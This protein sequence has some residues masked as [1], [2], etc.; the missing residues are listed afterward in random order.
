[1]S[2]ET[3]RFA[4]WSL[5]SL[6]A[7]AVLTLIV[8][9]QTNNI[10][11]APLPDPSTTL[12]STS[13]TG[14]A[15]NLGSIEGVI[16]PDGS[17]VAFRT[18]AFNIT[19]PESIQNSTTTTQVVVKDLSTGAV[20]VVSVD[21]DGNYGNGVFNIN[22]TTDGHHIALSEDGRFVA[23]TYTGSNLIPNDVNSNDVFV[24]D[25]QT[26]ITE[27]ISQSTDGVQANGRSEEPAISADGRYVAFKS[28]A[29]NLDPDG[30]PGDGGL[31]GGTAGNIYLR[32]RLLGTT[33]AL[34]AF[35]NSD[36]GQPDISADGSRVVFQAGGTAG[37][38]LW[39][40]ETGVDRQITFNSIGNNIN[41]Q[42]VEPSISGNGR[43]VAFNTAGDVFF[44]DP[45]FGSTTHIYVLDLDAPNPDLF[46]TQLISISPGGDYGDCFSWDPDLDFE[47]RFVAFRSCADNLGPPEN[48]DAFSDIFVHDR[49]VGETR[50]VSV[51]TD[52]TFSDDSFALPF[53]STISW[54][55]RFVSW[56]SGSTTFSPI[57]GDDQRDVFV[58]DQ[59][60]IRGPDVSIVLLEPNPSDFTD[61]I[62]VRVTADDTSNGDNVITS[63]VL[64]VG[65]EEIGELTPDD[66]FLD[67]SIEG[68]STTVSAADI[69]GGTRDF[70]IQAFDAIG[71]AGPP[72]CESHR[73]GLENRPVTLTITSIRET[74]TSTLDGGIITEQANLYAEAWFNLIILDDRD[75]E[76]NR[77]DAI[78]AGERQY[79]FWVFTDQ[80]LEDVDPVTIRLEIWDRD[81]LLR[82][83]DDLADA[84]PDPTTEQLVIH[85]DRQTGR[86][87]GAVEW[88]QNCAVGDDGPNAVEVCFDVS[89]WSSDGDLDDDAL[90]DGW[91]VNG[92]NAFNQGTLDSTIDVDLPAMGANLERKDLFVE[93]DC[94]VDD[95]NNDGDFTDL[96]DHSH[97]VRDDAVE[98]VVAS[99][100]ESPEE[101]VDGTTGVQLHVDTGDYNGAGVVN[102]YIVPRGVVG[103]WG[104]YGGGTR[105]IE[106]GWEI[107]SFG[108]DDDPGNFY[109]LK[110][111]FFNPDREFT[112]RYGLFGHQTN[113]R[114]ASFDCTSGMG[115]LP[116]NDF[117]VTL[118]GYRD[119][120]GDNDG[121]RTCWGATT[122]NN[123]DEDGDGLFDEDPVD[124]V[125]DDG[126]CVPG[127]D[128]N[129]DGDECS[130]GDI[131]VDEDGGHSLGSLNE[132]AGTF[133]HELGHTLGLR[134]GGETHE[135]N[136]PNHLSVMNYSFQDCRIPAGT[137]LPGGCDYSRL[138]LPDLDETALDECDGAD[139]NVHGLGPMDWDGSG[140]F[141]GPTCSPAFPAVSQ[142]IN[143]G[144][145][146][147][148]TVLGSF[149][150]WENLVYLFRLQGSF[151]DGFP[152][153]LPVEA[154][155][156]DLEHAH[157]TLAEFS[158]PA[159]D[160]QGFASPVFPGGEVGVLVIP[161]NVGRGLATTLSVR[162][163]SPEGDEQ[164]TEFT[165][166]PLQILSPPQIFAGFGGP[167]PAGAQVG[168]TL[169][170]DVIAEFTGISG[171]V[172]TTTAQV[173]VSVVEDTRPPTPTPLPPTPTP[174]ATPV[175]PTPTPVPP[176]P[177]P[178]PAA[179][180]I[181]IAPH[182]DEV[183][184]DGVVFFDWEDFP[185]L[186]VE[187]VIEIVSLPGNNLVLDE[188][189]SD[190]EFSID[191]A[192]AL[193]PGGYIWQVTALAFEGFA[194]S[195]EWTFTV[196]DEPLPPGPT[197]TPIPPTPTAVAYRRPPHRCRLLPRLH[198]CR[199]HR[200]SRRCHPLLRP[201][202][203]PPTPTVPPT[204]TPTP[205]PPTPTVPPTT[206][207]Y[208][209]TTNTHSAT[210]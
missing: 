21:S 185:S 135:N 87:T 188:F 129:D 144:D 194:Q 98:L 27:L 183:L 117:F 203:V 201:T 177:T 178:D 171:L 131:G 174:T 154:D 119:L 41:G 42:S 35:S 50:R 200:P 78:T 55:G 127:T 53:K 48:P 207:A 95:G 75:G 168:D 68:L 132:Q 94:L 190:S 67:S 103:T 108:T 153:E 77:E 4:R 69:G 169:I 118:G 58:R 28:L 158:D 112:H 37:I 74:E 191:P 56:D 23:F 76:N 159:F 31:G 179:G 65:D 29:T 82:G 72:A 149:D 199:Q 63:V 208:S 5:L 16:S 2:H 70:C 6:F 134:H 195:E 152:G 166:V 164:V 107:I 81:G 13:D 163:I 71:N 139:H 150:G 12:V 155:D 204:N 148:L 15:G 7:A 161:T 130:W 206:H 137:D 192:S 116:G 162:I 64:T 146:T 142:N 1:M 125:D 59:G 126:D 57:D 44:S 61:V 34:T 197:A 36:V 43:Y 187:Y 88:P 66:G 133:M 184:D 157:E 123:I 96:E 62:D 136:K 32:D 186:N 79:P 180:V 120:D 165:N 141:E 52:G 97:C 99:F 60:D 14:E 85:V 198:Q 18:S 122:A 86:W 115:E 84:S 46:N 140:V 73:V 104:D 19:G 17:V 128:T 210:Y 196:S 209:G 145:G 110:D 202:P 20:E 9:S 49:I 138:T 181:L 38:R 26:G 8:A 89:L 124:G 143:P 170:Y 173:E 121:D 102:R 51:A 3:R 11:A 109:D 114:A 93:L 91:E 106:D 33:I 151:A 176:T 160:L 90:L 182:D 24:H 105:I 54:D 167:V 92:L 40:R 189:T 205:V 47:G 175:L 193:P 100:A 39:E 172:R 80:V 45:N 10:G 30:V 113:A 25:R 22:S 111:Q 101:N 83:E 156:L 147:D